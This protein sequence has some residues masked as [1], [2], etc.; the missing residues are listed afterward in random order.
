MKVVKD[1]R[2]IHN[3]N[4]K[5][6]IR[7]MRKIEFKA[8][9]YFLFEDEAILPD[10]TKKKIS[11]LKCKDGFIGVFELL[12]SGV[13]RSNKELAKKDHKVVKRLKSKLKEISRWRDKD[14]DA[15]V[16]KEGVQIVI[17]EE[18][19]Y[20]ILKELLEANK[21][22]SKISEIVDA[23]WDLIENAPDY[24]VPLALEREG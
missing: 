7:V 12:W 17:L 13:D 3:L 22:T 15:R 10:G 2:R 23:M 5:R 20:N 6:G 19:E 9:N 4:R 1:W 8:E 21:F 14:E 11:Y 24:Q 18:D 16:L